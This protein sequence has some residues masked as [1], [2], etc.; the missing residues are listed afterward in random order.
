MRRV[1]SAARSLWTSPSPSPPP[2]LQATRANSPTA[3][4]TAAIPIYQRD[5]NSLISRLHLIDRS[6]SWRELLSWK[7]EGEWPVRQ[8]SECEAGRRSAE[9]PERGYARDG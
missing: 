6:R 3:A 5:E 7:G 8:H 1:W 2:P 4:G 9:Q